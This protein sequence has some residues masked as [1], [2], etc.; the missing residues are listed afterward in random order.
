MIEIF[1]FLGFSLSRTPRWNIAW[2]ANPFSP[3]VLWLIT[4]P[5][6]FTGIVKSLALLFSPTETDFYNFRL[7]LRCSQWPPRKCKCRSEINKLINWNPSM[8]TH[9]TIKLENECI[10]LFD[11]TLQHRQTN[12]VF[13]FASVPQRWPNF[14]W[15][16]LWGTRERQVIL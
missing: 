8:M 5:S 15:R 12:Y 16:K 6:S 3:L 2:R 11:P 4:A 1:Y 7:R 9:L 13:H 14:V 10:F